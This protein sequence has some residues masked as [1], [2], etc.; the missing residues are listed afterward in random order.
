MNT[1]QLTFTRFIAAILIVIY[2][3]GGDVF[4][5]SNPWLAPFFHHSNLGVSYFFLLSGFVMVVAYGRKNKAVDYGNYLQNRAAR[6]LPLYYFA[7][8]LMLIYF[9]IRI[10]LLHVHSD[11]QP[12]VT[13]VVLHTLLIQSWLPGKA[14]SINTAAWSLSVEAFFYLLFPLLWNRLYSI[15]SFNKVLFFSVMFFLISQI[16][17]HFL[18]GA[19]P[20][21]IAYFFYLPLL[22]L[23]EFVCGNVVGLL[24]LRKQQ[25]FE[26]N[27]FVHVL[28]VFILSVLAV[29]CIPETRINFHNGLFIIFFAPLV[30]FL[31]VDKSAL[32]RTFRKKFFI[33]LGEISY[34]IYILQFPVYF[35]F[36]ATLTYF[37]HKI[38]QPLFFVYLLILIVVSGISF[39]YIETPMRE[40]IRSFP[41]KKRVTVL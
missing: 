38:N 19:Y 31:A 26:R 8:L 5:F 10:S 3:F 6:I 15:I 36:T 37:G 14:T 2:H 41:L 21:L 18:I 22:H 7:M 24:F 23:N 9:F 32:A 16:L 11:Y 1:D 30:Y 39:R 34:G 20:Q 35:F 40:K 27:T 4:P 12:S 17:F 25:S 33:Y 28:I 13:D 29:Y